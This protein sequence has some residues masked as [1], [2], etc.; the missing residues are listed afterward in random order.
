[1]SDIFGG[2][3]F[4]RLKIGILGNGW[5]KGQSF[6]E[7]MKHTCTIEI[8]HLAF[9]FYFLFSSPWVSFEHIPVHG[10]SES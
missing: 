7:T 1:M 10:T 9:L 5:N 8:F 4:K 3:Y 2:L 6:L